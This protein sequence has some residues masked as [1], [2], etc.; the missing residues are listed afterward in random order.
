MRAAGKTLAFTRIDFTDHQ[1][2]LVAFGREYWMRQV[3][4]HV[5]LTLCLC[6]RSYEVRG[7]D[8]QPRG[9]YV[10]LGRWQSFYADA[11][12]CPIARKM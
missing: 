10:D 8:Y 12:T 7:V 1:G 2:R 6:L 5:I 9:E 11:D 3:S 4:L